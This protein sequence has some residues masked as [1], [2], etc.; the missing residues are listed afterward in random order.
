MAGITGVFGPSSGC[1]V[2]AA[3][4]SDWALSATINGSC[5]PSARASSLALIAEVVSA[6]AIVRRKPCARIAAS[7]APR[8]SALTSWPA[9]ASFAANKPPTAPNPGTALFTCHRR[10]K[11][12]F[13]ATLGSM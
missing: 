3:V 4:A 7:V 10:F 9:R 11:A 13:L 5:W 12:M 1:I 2:C 8:A 6:P